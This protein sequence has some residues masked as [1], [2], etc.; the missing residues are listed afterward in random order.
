[1]LSDTD[2]FDVQGATD[3]MSFDNLYILSYD[4]VK[5]AKAAYKALSKDENILSV[6]ADKPAEIAAAVTGNETKANAD[7]G[8]QKSNVTVAVLDTGY[9]TSYYSGDRILESAYNVSGSVCL[10]WNRICPL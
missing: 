3:V 4:S 10:Y 8:K 2:A 5:A 9:D 1:M 7:Y 6:E